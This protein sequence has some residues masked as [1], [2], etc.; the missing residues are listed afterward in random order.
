[1]SARITL[2]VTKG[3]LKGHV[4]EFTRPTRCLVG[5]ARDCDIQVRN[6]N[7]D[8]EV[9]RHQCEFAIDPPRIVVRDLG[10]CNGTFVNDKKI[11]QRPPFL[12]PEETDL[13]MF[14]PKELY[15]GD[16]VRGGNLVLRVGV[17]EIPE[18]PESEEHLR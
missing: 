15:N 4:F 8:V 14:P 6:R 9:S 13:R 2:T 1:M 18:G 11:G 16:E 10:S 12:A 7:R 17:D 3:T 5:R